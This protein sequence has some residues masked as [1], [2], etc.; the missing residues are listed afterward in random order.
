[1]EKD[2]EFTNPWPDLLTLDPQMKAQGN[3]TVY[4][5]N[6]GRN[7]GVFENLARSERCRF[8]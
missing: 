1:M 2:G 6:D 4:L 8:V 3:Q 5:I 7:D